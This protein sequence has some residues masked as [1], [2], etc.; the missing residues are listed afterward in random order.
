MKILKLLENLTP[1]TFADKKYHGKFAASE[2]ESRKNILGSGA[3]STARQNKKD[4]HSVIK[5]SNLP[6][7][8]DE[9]FNL[10]ATY[11]AK[12]PGAM[13]NIHMPKVHK[14]N[15]YTD[16][17][18]KHIDVYD[19]EKLI[20]GS[21]INEK[22]YKH[23]IDSYFHM[24]RALVSYINTHGYTGVVLAKLIDSAVKSESGLKRVK[25]DELR[26]AIAIVRNSIEYAKD[27]MR[28]DGLSAQTDLHSENLMYRR[29][30]FGIQCVIADP[31]VTI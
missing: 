23:M 25:S 12:T 9:G 18:G 30:P 3:F 7:R 8:F 13:D 1:T 10:F 24:S 27:N 16:K 15:K 5:H 2:D 14:I 17:K 20:D 29:T 11:I 22:E 28:T 6:L 21:S 4:P 31:L 19:M 26:D